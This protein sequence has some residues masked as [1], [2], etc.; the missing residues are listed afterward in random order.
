MKIILI[1][2]DF[3]QNYGLVWFSGVLGSTQS[4]VLGIYTISNQKLANTP[5]PVYTKSGEENQFHVYYR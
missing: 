5:H 3:K 1:K 4:S 2:E